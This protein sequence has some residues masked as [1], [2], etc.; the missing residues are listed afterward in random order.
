[1]ETY[2]LGYK[3]LVVEVVV[4]KDAASVHIRERVAGSFTKRGI[5]LGEDEWSDLVKVSATVLGEAEL[6]RTRTWDI[7]TRGRRV[8]VEIFKGAP[9]VH[10]RNFWNRDGTGRA[11]PTKIGTVLSVDAFRELVDITPLVSEDLK[12]T[13]A[14]MDKRKDEKKEAMVRKKER[15]DAILKKKADELQQAQEIPLDLDWDDDDEP[16]VKENRRP[17]SRRG[18]RDSLTM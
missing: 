9:F 5:A 12:R 6:Y 1:M 2:E 10:I 14:D 13:L 8:Y 7:G 3:N 17:S 18:R 16:S 4:F 11:I 15:L